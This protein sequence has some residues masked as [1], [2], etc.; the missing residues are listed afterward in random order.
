M[1]YRIEKEENGGSALVIDG[2]E[3]GISSDPYSGLGMLSSVNLETSGEIAVGYPITSAVTT[4]GTLAKPI[5]RSTCYFPTYK[6]QGTTTGLEQRYA[7]LD[8]GSQVWEL[9][10]TSITG[11]WNFL[12]SNNSTTGAQASDGIAYWLGYLFKFRNDSID[13]WD[14]T[15]WHTGWQ[16]TINAG[17]PHFAYVATNNQLYFTNGNFIGRIFAPDVST[18]DPTNVSTYDFNSEILEIPVYDCALSL[19]EVGGG[20]TPQSTLLIGGSQNAIYPWDK[21]SSSFSLPIYVADSYIG[22]MVSANQNA[23]IFPGRFSGRGRIYITNGSQADVFF[24]IPD[25]PFGQQEPYFT[26]GDAIFHRNNLIFGTALVSNGGTNPTSTNIF[27]LE[28][29]KP[30]TAF[31]GPTKLFRSIST[32]ATSTGYLN[33]GVLIPIIAPNGTPVFPLGFGYFVGWDNTSGTQ[34]GIGYSSTT[35][36]IESS[37]CSI[38]TDLIPVGTYL[39]KK[40]FENIEFKLRTPMASGESIAITPIIDSVVGNPYIFSPPSATEVISSVASMNFTGAQWLQFLVTLV[41]N[42]VSSGMRLKEIRLR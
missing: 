14:G 42:S 3:N 31:A 35:A 10:A 21:I 18:F 5:A 12:S 27:A 39:Q 23:F 32:I 4:G 37:G 30:A 29:S 17:V 8:S 25:F 20:S 34:F 36:G 19:C 33:T 26:W 16:T 38:Y 2:W 24:K 6:T 41:G 13:Y 7:M 15:T 11:T 1:A 22:R 9:A 28:I 40:T